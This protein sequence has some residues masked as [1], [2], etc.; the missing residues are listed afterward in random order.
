[1][2]EQPINGGHKMLY[3][4]ITKLH[5]LKTDVVMIKGKQLAGD[6]RLS[7]SNEFLKREFGMPVFMNMVG[8]LEYDDLFNSTYLYAKGKMDENL[9]DRD[10]INYL[11]RYINN[12][13]TFST[14]LWFVK[15]NSVATENSFLYMEHSD[16]G[17]SVTSNSRAAYFSNARGE[18]LMTLFNS[19]ELQK[20]IQFFNALV[21]EESLTRE[22]KISYEY[23]NNEASRIERFFYY[24]QAA[25]TQNY[26]PSRISLYCTMLETLLSTDT[27][28][29][30]HKIAERAARIIGGS[31]DERTEIYRKV[32]DAYSIRSSAV[33]GDKL[34]KAFRV[35]DRLQQVSV[36][37]DDILRRLIVKI[38]S[39]EEHSER[40]H[41]ADHDK[42]NEWFLE[43]SLR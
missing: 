31:L 5:F 38:I 29:I 23:L 1:M 33:H 21:S 17:P 26:L 14:A 8:L 30:T 18:N 9:N 25:R 24:L 34:R 3:K 35:E 4:V 27:T 19:D 6:I 11:S 32:K 36:E 10:R 43:I 15:D 42:L 13:Q 12:A 41:S 28:E 22:T 37:I 16:E 39:D 40:F 2:F 20:A 7:N